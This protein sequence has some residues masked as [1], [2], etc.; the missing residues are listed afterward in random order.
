MLA[1][2][3]QLFCLLVELRNLL[4]GS[5]GCFQALIEAAVSELE[6]PIP[7]QPV[8]VRSRHWSEAVDSMQQWFLIEKRNVSAMSAEKWESRSV[9]VIVR[10]CLDLNEN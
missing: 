4:R 10:R 7:D 5:L 3:C 9:R 1:A 2:G 6:T 8:S